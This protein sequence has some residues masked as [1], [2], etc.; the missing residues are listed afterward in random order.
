MELAML[1]MVEKRGGLIDRDAPTGLGTDQV[2]YQGG[3]LNLLD[4]FL[5]RLDPAMEEIILMPHLTLFG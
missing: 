1:F 2:D 3:F 5:E 4:Q